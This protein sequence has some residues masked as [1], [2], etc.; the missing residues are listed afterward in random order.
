MRA[1]VF[2]GI[3]DSNAWN[4]T[5]TRAGPGSTSKATKRL[6]AALSAF[7]VDA[8]VTS[9]LDAGCS[10]CYWQPAFPGYVG[11]D[12]VPAAIERARGAH[13]DRTFLVAD[14]CEDELPQVEVV[15]CRDALQH[16]SLED[17]T[18][19]IHNFRRTGAWLLLAG[20][21]ANG[22]NRNIVTG[23]YYEPDL[24]QPPFSLGDPVVRFDDSAWDDG[25]RWPG[26]YL[27]GFTL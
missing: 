8:G 9:V 6:A 19:A 20:S 2:A 13:P 3:Y 15:L 14:V 18:A 24:T 4:G 23:S 11:V 22:M 7:F 25:E 21:F 10:E 5:V 17:G 26:K 1:D 16:M 27:T 12:I